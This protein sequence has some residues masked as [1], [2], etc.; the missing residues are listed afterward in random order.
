[1]VRFCLYRARLIRNYPLYLVDIVYRKV[2]VFLFEGRD[3]GLMN[4]IIELMS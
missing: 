4:E 1:M 3:S 2:A